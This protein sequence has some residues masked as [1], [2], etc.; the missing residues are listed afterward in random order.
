MKNVLTGKNV[1]ELDEKLIQEF[2]DVTCSKIESCAP[3]YIACATKE[4][5]MD[6]VFSQYFIEEIA[7]IVIKGMK[8]DIDM[9]SGKM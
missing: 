3:V 4:H 1:L 5:D 2:K 8:M 7:A 6:K 9:F